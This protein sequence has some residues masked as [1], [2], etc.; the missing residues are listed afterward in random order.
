MRR[1]KREFEAETSGDP[2]QATES[3]LETAITRSG[4][5]MGEEW[6]AILSRAFMHAANENKSSKNSGN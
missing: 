6:S 2:L 1:W 4:E 3:Q 5:V